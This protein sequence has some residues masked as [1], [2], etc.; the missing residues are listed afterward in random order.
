L[1]AR[2]RLEREE[3]ERERRLRISKYTARLIDESLPIAGTLAERYLREARGLGDL[4]PL[5]AE[6]RFHPAVWCKE[7]KSKHPALLVPC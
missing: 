1:R 3:R 6:L 4:L 2:E 7:T 5:P